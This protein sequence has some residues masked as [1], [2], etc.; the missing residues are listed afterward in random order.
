M[1]RKM[2]E[3]RRMK[4]NAEEKREEGLSE[5]QENRDE[6]KEVTDKIEECPTDVDEE[7]KKA[8]DDVAAASRIDYKKEMKKV[9]ETVGEAGKE[10]EKTQEKASDERKKNN[11]VSEELK[12]VQQISDFGKVSAKEG[13]K[14]AE[15]NANKYDDVVNAEKKEQSDTEKKVQNMIDEFDTY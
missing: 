8:V 15:D 13:V 3:I 1:G 10:S 11:E 14:E 9:E 5:G 4:E 12:E 2:K 6:M 7:T